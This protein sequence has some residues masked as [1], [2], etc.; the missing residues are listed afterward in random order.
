MGPED[1]KFSAS[2]PVLY[3][4]PSPGQVIN[5]LMEREDWESAIKTPI[6]MLPLGSGNALCAATLYESKWVHAQQY[7]T[8]M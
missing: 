7:Y 1:A 6:G 8:T 4:S 5:G 2:H 3:L